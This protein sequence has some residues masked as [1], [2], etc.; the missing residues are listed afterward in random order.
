MLTEPI[1]PMG[2]DMV[3][4]EDVRE[5][6][7]GVKSPLPT[8]I[9]TVCI[10]GTLEEKL[11]AASEAGFDG[12][13]IFEPDF[14]AAP[15][16][17]AAVRTRCAD[18][19]LTIDLYQPFRDFDSVKPDVCTA[20][21]RRAEHKFE[22]MEQLGTE[23]LLVCSSVSED[24]VDD[25][26]RIAEQLY[27]LALRA[28]RHGIR[29]AYEALAWGRHVNTYAHSWDI[30]RR[31]DHPALGLCLD[32][33][34][35]LSRGSDPS[36]IRA[37]PGG[38]IFFI[39]LSDAPF[40]DMNVL[41]WSRHYRLF[42]GQG[43]FDLT[44]FLGHVLAAG[45]TG[46]LSLEVF[47][48][49]YRQSEPHRAA[50]DGMRSLLLLQETTAAAH[51][52]AGTHQPALPLPGVSP[53]DGYAF[54][55]I[56]VNASSATVVI[57]ALTALGFANT[58]RHRTKPVDLW[59]HGSARI[60]LNTN[61]EGTGTAVSALGI[62]TVDT[63]AVARRGQAMLAPVVPRTT[64]AG[65]V[66]IPGV[67]APDGTG[68][69][70]CD[71]R[72]GGSTW[73]SDFLM[74]GS[75]SAGRA[76]S[77]IDHVALTQPYDRFDEA[78]LFYRAILGLCTAR[79]SEIA[80]PFG[81]IRNL[82]VADPALTVRLSLTV[83]VLRRGTDWRP[84][85]LN[86]QHVAFATDDIFAAAK[87]ANSTAGIILPIPANYYDDLDARLSI[88]YE[89]LSLMRNLGIMYDRDKNG[90]FLHFYT[91]ILDGRVF[92]EVVQRVG[93]YSGY[94][95]VNAPVRMAAHRRQ[96]SQGGALSGTV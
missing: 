96:R 16:T 49:V 10:S 5:S 39:Q 38:K 83:S 58:G 71:S 43:S 48:D 27:A 14:I 32:S 85:V 11:H 84:A 4:R 30:V 73:R 20:N 64:A 72:R 62:E 56:A 40:M 17:P 2:A 7:G 52:S 69:L 55:E 86:P 66:D 19:G 24:A 67:A 65:E 51:A 80:A 31:A 54:V 63:D 81:L 44:A 92:F 88:P 23:L 53:L 74:N 75:R 22:L 1:A 42:P 60:L 59:E 37:I 35:I 90:E 13:E 18:L 3:D 41:Q 15:F 25:D 21:M 12:I 70:L 77:G 57:D 89:Q 34:H 36:K 93:G 95:E 91:R 50:V 46:P 61:S 28:E 26:D 47:N 9:A 78:I 79:T 82:A 29:I 33:F 94:G 8:A 6:H 87:S 68:V 76:I 45:Y